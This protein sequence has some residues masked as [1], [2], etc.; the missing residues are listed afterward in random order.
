MTNGIWKIY[1]EDM[2]VHR[3]TLKLNLIIKVKSTHMY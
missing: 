2:Q 3:M 1:S